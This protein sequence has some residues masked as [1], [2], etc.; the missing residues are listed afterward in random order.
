[1]TDIKRVTWVK[2]PLQPVLWHPRGLLVQC[3]LAMELFMEWYITHELL[4]ILNFSIGNTRI[5]SKWSRLDL[6]AIL[7]IVLDLW[8]SATMLQQ[9]LQYN[10]QYNLVSRYTMLIHTKEIIHW[11]ALYYRTYFSCWHSLPSQ[12]E[13]PGTTQNTLYCWWDNHPRLHSWVAHLP[14]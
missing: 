8:S 5:A 10:L 6:Y 7:K 1:M 12:L 11:L 4:Y 13:L 9:N 2:K 3:G 14:S